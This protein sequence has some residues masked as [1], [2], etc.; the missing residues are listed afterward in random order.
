VSA[1][2]PATAPRR[3]ARAP[4]LEWRRRVRGVV[5]AALLASSLVALPALVGSDWITTFTSVAI[6]SVVALGFG[7]L[8]GRV[9]MISLGQVALLHD[10]LLGRRD[11]SPTRPSLP[12]PLLLLARA[13]SPARSARSSACPR[14]GSPVSTW[15]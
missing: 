7:I 12:F 14:C 11:G 1:T 5:I 9:G 2:A 10:R 3:G 8:Y 6:Y 4:R 15:R 13:R